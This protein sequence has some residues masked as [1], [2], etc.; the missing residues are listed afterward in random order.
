MTG[1]QRTTS[2]A[3]RTQKV[4]RR[5]VSGDRPVVRDSASENRRP[6]VMKA[7]MPSPITSRSNNAP[8]I[9]SADRN[10]AESRSPAREEK[11]ASAATR[12]PTMIRADSVRTTQDRRDLKCVSLIQYF[13]RRQGRNTLTVMMLATSARIDT[14][15][16]DGCSVVG[17]ETA[18]A[19][20]LTSSSKP[21]PATTLRPSLAAAFIGTGTM[22]Q[23]GSSGDRHATANPETTK[24]STRLP[25][26]AHTKIGKADSNSGGNVTTNTM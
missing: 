3:K 9:S 17:L 16:S 14:K 6:G 23:A 18:L 12:A 1:G 15:F 8:P 20:M 7:R 21:A 5:P 2:A 25:T 22:R 13:G 24:N 19:A 10:S 11:P 4:R 26:L